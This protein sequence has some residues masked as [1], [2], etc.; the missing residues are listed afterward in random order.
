MSD[1]LILSNILD[2]LTCSSQDLDYRIRIHPDY[3]QH[4]IQFCL[5]P[6]ADHDKRFTQ[7]FERII[8]NSNKLEKIKKAIVVCK[9]ILRKQASNEELTENEKIFFD[10]IQMISNYSQMISD[11]NEIKKEIYEKKEEY[12]NKYRSLES[13]LN[14]QQKAHFAWQTYKC[15]CISNKIPLPILQ[16]NPI[17]LRQLTEFDMREIETKNAKFQTMIKKISTENMRIQELENSLSEIISKLMEMI[18]KCQFSLEID[19]V[20]CCLRKSEEDSH[21]CESFKEE[22]E[23]M[24]KIFQELPIKLDTFFSKIEKLITEFKAQYEEYDFIWILYY[25]CTCGYH[26]GFQKSMYFPF[27]GKPAEDTPHIPFPDVSSSSP[28][29]KYDRIIAYLL[30]RGIKL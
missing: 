26:H 29:E 20:L 25:Y 17:V 1:N 12:D 27:P 23:K 13:K 18:K 9:E 4:F 7:S 15:F 22:F 28:N 10:Y 11:F 5:N 24:K 19:S 2:Q 6:K 30:A 14:G 3:F 8:A 21:K 16:K